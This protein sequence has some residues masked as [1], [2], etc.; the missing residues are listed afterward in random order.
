MG[1]A[2][3][4]GALANA[5]AINAAVNAEIA[6]QTDMD[7]YGVKE[8]WSINVSAGDCEDYVL[9]KRAR[10]LAAGWHSSKLRIATVR[11]PSGE[12]HAVLVVATASA[13][14]VFDNLTDDVRDWSEAPYRWLTIQSE[15]SPI[16]WQKVLVSDR[17]A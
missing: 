17:R 14:L 2:A 15:A 13:D 10:L 4:D 8:L 11:L 6:P 5:L 3:G 9:T 16:V 12:L 1:P 7:R